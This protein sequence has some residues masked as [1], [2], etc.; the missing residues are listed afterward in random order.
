MQVHITGFKRQPDGTIKSTTGPALKLTYSALDSAQRQY[1][2][3]GDK[4]GDF[5]GPL[6][7]QDRELVDLHGGGLPDV[8]QL[9]SGLPLVWQNLGSGEF[10]PART[11]AKIS[12]R[13]ILGGAHRDHVAVAGVISVVLNL[14]QLG[15][16][17]FA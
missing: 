5:P 2:L 12:I 13:H 6:G 14:A 15:G 4:T 9:G 8:V 7:T 16:K 1:S 17:A 10:A 11:I 3:I